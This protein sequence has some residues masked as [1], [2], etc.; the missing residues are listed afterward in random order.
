M[1]AK[2]VTIVSNGMIYPLLVR[3]DDNFKDTGVEYF[4]MPD[5]FVKE[6]FKLLEKN[7]VKNYNWH[8]N[9]VHSC[10]ISS[11]FTHN[12]SIVHN[13]NY[14]GDNDTFSFDYAP[15]IYNFT[16][17]YLDLNT[18]VFRELYFIDN[19]IK[20]L[21]DERNPIIEN[22]FFIF[23]NPHFNNFSPEDTLFKTIDF[24][25]T[26]YN[27]CNYLDI[28][29]LIRNFEGN[30][31]MSLPDIKLIYKSNI[32]NI[33]Y[34]HATSYPAF[35][36]FNSICQKTGRKLIPYREATYL[37]SLYDYNKYEEMVDKGLITKEELKDS[38][39]YAK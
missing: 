34:L 11:R 20:V 23:I 31:R 38:W 3:V 39:I 18:N 9:Q 35:I 17:E 8:Q 25:K 27:Y 21:D 37:T 22:V 19:K 29:M 33:R 4:E 13:K 36:Y 10:N 2:L 7:T 14:K 32:K 28:P 1:I 26:Y 6:N 5:P 16:T 30:D 24:K 12:K 15:L